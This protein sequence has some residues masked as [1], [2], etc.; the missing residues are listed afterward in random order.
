MRLNSAMHRNKN[1]L[2]LGVFSGRVEHGTAGGAVP[3]GTV[4][5]L[6][7]GNAELGFSLVETTI[8]EDLSYRF[9]GVPLTSAFNYTVGAVYGERLFSR[10][11]AAGQAT[12]NGYQQT[13]TLY[14]M[15]DDPQVVSVRRIDLFID[16][17]NLADLGAGW[18]ISQVIGYRNSSDRIYTSGRGFD[19]G[20]EAVLLLQFPT[21]AR[22]LS[23]D[24]NGRYV[25]IEDMERLPNAIID[26]LPVMPGDAHEVVLEFFLPLD[27]DLYYEQAFNNLVD[28]EI[29]LTLAEDLQVESGFLTLSSDSGTGDDLRVYTGQLAMEREA[30]LQ[31]AIIGDP[32]ATSSDDRNVITSENLPALMIAAGGLAAALLAGWALLMRRGHKGE[33]EL[34]S[35]VAELA[36]LEAD[37]DQ[38]RINHDLY[39]H[40][41]RE[42]KVR[43]AQMMDADD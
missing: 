26:T 18:L 1:R 43:L 30:R 6:Q 33:N 5:Q 13:I 41:R 11:L 20:R 31:F 9:A 34:D 7:Y 39:H 3:T 22:L 8:A 37:H 2:P 12:A 24:E 19:D 14:D 25:V 40:R 29:N 38:G 10:H 21:G 16:A 28:A 35:L 15:T 27:G 36:R 23:G 17:V 32:F 4:V 42:L